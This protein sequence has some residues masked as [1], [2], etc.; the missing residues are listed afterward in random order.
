MEYAD[1]QRY[2]ASPEWA[3]TRQAC[4][5]Y[6]RW[7]CSVCDWDWRENSWLECHHL[8]YK[9]LGH[10]DITRDLRPL[11]HGHHKKGRYTLQQILR[12]RA[13]Y[14][15]QKRLEGASAFVFRLLLNG[16]RCVAR[17]LRKSCLRLFNLVANAKLR[18]TASGSDNTKEQHW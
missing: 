3:A 14:R 8:H 5:A 6:R 2:M 11:C 16:S 10:E 7:A 13:A 18:K 17:C 15:W 12:D 9:T 1:R 4:F